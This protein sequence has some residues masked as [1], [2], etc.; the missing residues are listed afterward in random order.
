[1]LFEKNNLFLCCRFFCVIILRMKTT[2][3]YDA[4]ASSKNDVVNLITLRLNKFWAITSHLKEKLLINNT[5][6]FRLLGAINMLHNMQMKCKY[7]LSTYVIVGGK[8]IFDKTERIY[9]YHG[10]VQKK[11]KTSK[12]ILGINFFPDMF[13]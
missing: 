3:Y 6:M 10:I 8:T 1:M 2:F 4:T 9:H 13:M 7:S 5:K 11:K 12:F